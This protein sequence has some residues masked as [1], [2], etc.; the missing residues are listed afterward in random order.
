MAAG[1]RNRL[2][3][4]HSSNQVDDESAHVSAGFSRSLGDSSIGIAAEN[5]GN[6]S[7][8]NRKNE[9][10]SRREISPGDPISTGHSTLARM[11]AMT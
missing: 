9:R 10:R 1:S 6:V 11:F 2:E 4:P 8:H 7:E 5:P 3:N